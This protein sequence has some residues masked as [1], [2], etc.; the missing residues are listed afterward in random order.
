MGKT[1]MCVV[2]RGGCDHVSEGRKEG[3]QDNKIT[4]DAV[5]RMG[6]EMLNRNAFIINNVVLYI[7]FRRKNVLVHNL[8]SFNIS[9]QQTLRVLLRETRPNQRT[10]PESFLRRR[11]EDS[12]CTVQYSANCMG[13]ILCR[14]GKVTAV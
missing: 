8:F 5:S 6:S 11:R 13:W 4:T 14:E 10:N 9:D 1:T 3:T 12:F 7:L 2:V